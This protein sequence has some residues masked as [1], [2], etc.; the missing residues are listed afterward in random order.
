MPSSDVI[1]PDITGPNVSLQVLSAPAP[2]R[3]A[4]KTFSRPARL[5]R[6]AGIRFAAVYAALISA[7]AVAVALVLWLQTAGV[8]DSQTETAISLDTGD[9]AARWRE[10][11][12]PLLGQTIDDRVAQNVDGD[13]VYMLTDAAMRRIAGNL[14]HW[15]TGIDREQT[16]Y[17]LGVTRAGLRV[18]TR[19]AYMGFP[20]GSH[21]L[22]GRDI[23][24]RVKLRALV[25]RALL[26][27]LGVVLSAAI[28]GALLVRGLFT[29]MLSNV[30]A[31]AIAIADG[32]LSRRVIESGN[33]DEFDQLAQ[34]INDMLDR[35][36]R[37]M[38]GVRHVSNAIAHDLRT[39]IGRARARL[40]EAA[41]HAATPAELHRA[42]DRA[43]EDLDGITRVFQALLRIAEIEAGAQRAAFADIDL[44]PLLVDMAELYG[45]VAEERGIL[46]KVELPARLHGFGDAALIQQAVANLLDN[47]IKFSPEGGIVEL[48]GTN[49]GRRI[50][51]SVC[52]NGPGIPEP[53]RAHAAERFFRGEAARSTPGSGLG[54]AMV[55]AVAVLHGGSLT[56][57]DASPGLRAVL[58]IPLP[59]N[60]AGK[61]AWG[62]APQTPAR[63]A[64]GSASLK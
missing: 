49:Q 16:W 48:R 64:P 63:E 20:D 2:P 36:G 60:A 41:S 3:A 62:S 9:L 39:P 29:R 26:W 15:P 44:A 51:L 32:D 25:T 45:A 46:F 42:I 24:V 56:L 1:G 18:M 57:E 34:T 59:E 35:I 27:S 8:L 14:D 58:A 11:G 53:D 43:T 37:L 21:L 5:L 50:V 10:G 4:R 47:A 6:S 7:S 52:D 33:G 17:E 28:F 13:A 38:D 61:K 30:S 31:T 22:V 23:N 54:L 12:L 19:V 40:E 55:Q